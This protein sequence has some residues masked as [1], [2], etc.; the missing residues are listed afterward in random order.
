[1]VYSSYHFPPE[2]LSLLVDT[3]PKLC[4][5][6]KDVIY[7]FAGA[8]VKN[9]VFQEMKDR[10]H[11]DRH[12]INKYEIARNILVE[13]NELGDI[14]L[15]ERREIVK[16][17]V[18]FDDFSRCW[19]NDQIEAEGL[20]A[21]VQKMVKHKDTLTKI[22]EHQREKEKELVR[23]R[24]EE[25]KERLKS[26]QED[27]IEQQNIKQELSALFQESNSQK[28]GIKLEDLLNRFF[29]N[30]NILIKESFTIKGNNN[31]GIIQ[32]ID[33]AIEVDNHFYLV[34][35]KW[36]KD[37]LSP[38]DIGQHI[39]RLY[40]RSDVRG[41]F[42]SAS[43]Y[44]PASTIEIEKALSQRTIILFT[45]KEFLILLENEDNFK[46]LFR[47]KLESVLL[48]QKLVFN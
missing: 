16:R 34:E 29:K 6:K 24:Q 41:V 43:G 8:G 25:E 47:S 3:I 39:V 2:F 15:Q 7:F 23:Q 26:I 11:R 36:K 40:S 13:L 9:N 12:S 37:P 45:V 38:Q 31:E 33:G 4:K 1:M 46:K 27:K 21:K 22:Q 18:E 30:Q 28:R 19:S 35:M 5:S 17:V 48:E 42:I 10:V 44:T 32:Q 20:V 14:A